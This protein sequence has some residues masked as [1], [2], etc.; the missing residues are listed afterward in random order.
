MVIPKIKNPELRAFL[1]VLRRALLMIVV[2]IEHACEVY[3][4]ESVYAGFDDVILHRR[5]IDEIAKR[6]AVVLERD[7]RSKK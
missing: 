5:D 6:V 1:L 3:G 7:K 4:V 2:W